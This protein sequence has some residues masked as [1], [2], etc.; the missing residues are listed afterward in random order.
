MINTK[1]IEL[2]LLKELAREEEIDDS[3]LKPQDTQMPPEMALMQMITGA[4][5]TQAIYVAASLGIADL[6]KEGARSV[7][8]LASAT[9]AQP[10]HLY[11]VLRALASMGIFTEVAPRQFALTAI[12]EYLRSDVPGSLRALART[13]SD[14]WQWNCWREI[15]HTVKTGQPAMQRLYQVED[16]FDYLTQHPTSGAVFDDAMTGWARTIHTAVVDAYDFSGIQK[17][18]DVAGGHGA[19]LAA[20]LNANPKLQGTLFD[21]PTVVAGA[22]TLLQQEGVIDRCNTI[23]GSFF[24]TI[25]TGGDAYIMSHILHDW[26]DE[27]CVR[28]LKSIRQ[29]ISANGRLLIVEMLIPPGDTPHF[30]KLLD[31][32]MMA[33][34]SGGRERTE[35]E[36]Q[37]LLEIAGFQL[38]RIVP[39]AAPVSVIEAS[40]S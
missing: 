36:Y 23:G 15:L 5:V 6:L 8:D 19:L 26:G 4:W 17:I 28:I 37:H 3:P 11:R 29:S 1:D 35:A 33:I 22:E 40:P 7:D 9:G 13:V 2:P 12:A 14:E 27:D 38:T 32:T 24:E 25:P 39:T 10:S 16:T 30:G 18:V 20:I 31:I 34:F 21:L